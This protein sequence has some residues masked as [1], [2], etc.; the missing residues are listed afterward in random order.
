M[1]EAEWWEYDSVEE[2]ADAVAGDVGFIV[3]SALEARDSALIALPGGG[4]PRPIYPKIA[5][6]QLPWR[7]VTII[8][9]DARLAPMDHSAQ[10]VRSGLPLHHRKDDT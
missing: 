6:R 4:T 2:M 10:K 1:I 7:R 5:S 9:T 3:E 8:P